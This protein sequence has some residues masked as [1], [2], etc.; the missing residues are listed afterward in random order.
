M[1][2]PFSLVRGCRGDET[3]GARCV[4]VSRILDDSLSLALGSSLSSQ[5]DN[6]RRDARSRRHGSRPRLRTGA[7]PVDWARRDS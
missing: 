3:R 7:I 2:V 1:S 5:T 4:E 6:A